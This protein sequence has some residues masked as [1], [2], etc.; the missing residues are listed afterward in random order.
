MRVTKE[1]YK[2]LKGSIKKW[3]KIV[4][5]TG[6]DSGTDNCPLCDKFVNNAHNSFSCYGCPVLRKTDKTGCAGTPYPRFNSSSTDGKAVNQL[7]VLAAVDM[8]RFLVKLKKKC[9]VVYKDTKC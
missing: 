7:S 1:V 8:L 5:G 3:V 6:V 9:K 4:K 2:A